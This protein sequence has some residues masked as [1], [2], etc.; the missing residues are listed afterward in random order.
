M[1]AKKDLISEFSSAKS[2]DVVEEVPEIHATTTVMDSRV[3]MTLKIDTIRGKLKR[4]KKRAGCVE[5]I[6]IQG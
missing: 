3:V 2:H 1:E 4:V 6:Q 5:A